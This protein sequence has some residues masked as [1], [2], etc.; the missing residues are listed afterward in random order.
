MPDT[1]LTKASSRTYNHVAEMA[2]KRM[3]DKLLLCNKT[4]LNEA[5]FCV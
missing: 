1:A 5:I 3:E 2:R 4:T